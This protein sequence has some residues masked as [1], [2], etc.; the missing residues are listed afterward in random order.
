M[1]WLAYLALSGAII[2]ELIGTAALQASQ[3][4]SR[5]FASGITVASF[6][7]AVYLLSIAL[8][9]IP[10]GIAYA[11]WCGIGIALVT[12][13]GFVIFKQKMDF[14][15]LLGILLITIGSVVIMGFSHT[16]IN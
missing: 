15:A 7:I 12:G 13:I 1:N 11:A 4:F 5:P 9:S 16:K 14:P 6:A 2:F 3:H 10:V 8:K